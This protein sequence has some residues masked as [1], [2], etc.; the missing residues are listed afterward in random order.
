MQNLE[1][2]N[3]VYILDPFG[4]EATVLTTK[5]WTIAEKNTTMVSVSGGLLMNRL[6]WIAASV[7]ILAILYYLFSFTTPKV[8]RNRKIINE[9][10]AKFTAKLTYVNLSLPFVN[11]LP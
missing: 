7:V 9:E 1:L 11:I 8:K 10:P 3:L 4:L 5:Y 6:I 2:Q